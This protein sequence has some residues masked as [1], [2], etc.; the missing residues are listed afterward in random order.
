MARFFLGWSLPLLACLMAVISVIR[1][2]QPAPHTPLNILLDGDCS[3]PCFLNIQP[4]VTTLDDAVQRLRAHPW[5]GQVTDTLTSYGQYRNYHFRWSGQQPAFIDPTKEGDLF[6]LPGSAAD[7]SA[8]VGSILVPL[9]GLPVG[10]VFTALGLPDQMGI[11]VGKLDVTR[12]GLYVYHR[13]PAY[14]FTFV[15]LQRCPASLHVLLNTP[16]NTLYIGDPGRTGFTMRQ[17]DLRWLH[18]V[19]WCSLP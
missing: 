8:L 11:S 19:S 5:V 2:H 10:E 3:A 12:R 9:R 16:A 6:A 17:P 14:G 4:G 13:Y 7:R 1:A 18:H 15:T